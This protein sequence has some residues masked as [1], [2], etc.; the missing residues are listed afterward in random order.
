M[1]KMTPPSNFE[2]KP[3]IMG[4]SIWLLIFFTYTNTTIKNRNCKA[5]NAVNILGI[6]LSPIEAII[7]MAMQKKKLP[8]RT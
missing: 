2:L 1:S 7:V 8:N 6:K 5:D 3:F 4:L